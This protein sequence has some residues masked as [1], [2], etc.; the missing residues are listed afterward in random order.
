VEPSWIVASG[1]ILL[2]AMPHQL[3]AAGIRLLRSWVG[4]VASLGAV[5]W[6]YTQRPV[7]AIA[8]LM[9]LVSVNIIPV[10]VYE[11][12]TPTI[13]RDVVQPLHRRRWLQE[14]IMSEDP[15]VIQERS[16]NPAMLYD[17]VSEQEDSKW[18]D[19]SVLGHSPQAIQERP[20]PDYEDGYAG[21]R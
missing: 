11:R 20:V 2:A 12:F 6:I 3:G 10:T 4:I 18:H 21:Y 1:V 13:N 8:C 15:H 16:E 9:L 14:E 7:L 5:G 19:E 17:K